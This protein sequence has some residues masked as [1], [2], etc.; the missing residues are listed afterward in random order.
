MQEAHIL[1]V[2]IWFRLSVFF[3]VPADLQ[4]E[5]LFSL[6][7]TDPDVVDFLLR[8]K[9]SQHS[10]VSALFCVCDIIM[11]LDYPLM[12]FVEFLV[13]DFFVSAESHAFLKRDSPSLWLRDA[14]PMIPS[15]HLVEKCLPMRTT[16]LSCQ[17]NCSVN[18]QRTAV[19]SPTG[20]PNFLGST[21]SLAVLKR[22]LA[23][24][25]LQFLQT[26][27]NKILCNIY[28]SI[29][30]Y[31]LKGLLEFF[32]IMVFHFPADVKIMLLGLLVCSWS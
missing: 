1:D 17:M 16:P 3:Q 26:K 31:K 11:S 6:L 7:E 4:N 12:I 27:A 28:L 30:K 18:T 14:Y 25:L 5:V 15:K 23:R 2:I 24:P 20:P 13:F 22:A 8:R 21:N 29:M 19:H 32:G 10:W 9:A